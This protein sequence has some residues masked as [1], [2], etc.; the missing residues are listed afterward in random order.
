MR[1]DII[2]RPIP[3]KVFFSINNDKDTYMHQITKKTGITFSHIHN[4][5]RKFIKCGLVARENKG[6][7][8]KLT[9]TSKGKE[10]SNRLRELYKD[11]GKIQNAQA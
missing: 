10:I 2:V 3:A 4:L 6:R 8:V 7:I 1:E 5:V 11:M 9:L